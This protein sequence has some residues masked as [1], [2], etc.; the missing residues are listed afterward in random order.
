RAAL[1]RNASSRHSS[2]AR[3]KMGRAS[4]FASAPLL[5]NTSAAPSVT[6]FPVT[7]EVKSPLRARKPPVSAY[8][9]VRLCTAGSDQRMAFPS[10]E[11]GARMPGT[12]VPRG[13]GPRELALHSARPIERVE[14][15]H[16][17]EESRQS[18]ER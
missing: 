18:K 2:T 15:P 14:A 8:P 6:N 1:S 9:A 17:S 16:L 4:V 10:E 12:I 5:P 3:Q 13:P 11:Q 7:C